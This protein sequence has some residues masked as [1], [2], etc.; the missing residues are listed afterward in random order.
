MNNLEGKT[1]F[2]VIQALINSHHIPQFYNTNLSTN[3]SISVI[4]VYDNLEDAEIIK[5]RNPKNRSVIISKFYMKAMT[6]N[7]KDYDYMDIC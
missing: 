6:D 7:D 2:V 5:N 4:G 3:K 1:V